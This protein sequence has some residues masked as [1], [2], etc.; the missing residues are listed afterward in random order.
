MAYIKPENESTIPSAAKYALLIDGENISGDYAKIIMDIA[1]GLGSITIRNVYGNWGNDTLSKW[2]PKISEYSLTP[3]MVIS[4]IKGKNTTDM[5]I[6]MDAI[7]IANRENVDGIIIVSSDSDYAGLAKRLRRYGKPVVGMGNAQTNKS[8]K[9]S[10]T[11]FFTLNKSKSEKTTVPKT[12]TVEKP[13]VEKGPDKPS[14][15]DRPE[16]MEIINRILDA[17]V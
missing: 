10:C 16:L 9:N 15:P 11:E 17:A 1:F 7:E 14:I 8:F 12:E 5:E 6:A 2:K 13:K 3:C 4:N